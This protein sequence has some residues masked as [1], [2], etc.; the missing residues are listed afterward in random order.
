MVLRESRVVRS[1]LYLR[2]EAIVDD[3]LQV[4]REDVVDRQNN[5]LKLPRRSFK[6]LA[7]KFLF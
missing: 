1:F 7:C 2:S 4:R 5:P 6:H 3:L